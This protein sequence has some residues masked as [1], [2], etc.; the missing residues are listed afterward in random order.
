MRDPTA[1]SG[2]TLQP[3]HFLAFPAI[4]LDFLLVVLISSHDGKMKSMAFSLYKLPRKVGY[5]LSGDIMY[6]GLKTIL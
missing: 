5:I 4:L 1:V 2:E 6:A 3:I